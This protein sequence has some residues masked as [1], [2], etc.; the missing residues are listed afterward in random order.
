MAYFIV[1]LFAWLVGIGCGILIGSAFKEY[2]IK[3]SKNVKR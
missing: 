1:I 3:R 2:E